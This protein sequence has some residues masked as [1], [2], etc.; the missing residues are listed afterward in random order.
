MKD[1]IPIIKSLLR[2]RMSPLL[3]ILQIAVTF[4]VLVNSVYLMVEK[5]LEIDNPTGLNEDAIFSFQMSL[6]GEGAE[7][8]VANMYRDIEAIRALDSVA[9]ATVVNSVPLSHRGSGFEVRLDPNESGYITKSA[10][11][12]GG[13]QMIETMG[14]KLIA[15][16][17]FTPADEGTLVNFNLD[18]AS[19]IVITKALA[20]TLYPEYWNQALGKTIY[21]NE[22]PQNV[23]GIVEHLVGPW[24][25]WPDNNNSVI[26]PIVFMMS[27]VNVIVRAHEGKR[28]Q[29]MRDVVELLMKDPSRYIDELKSMNELKKTAYQAQNAAY[30][31]LQAVIIGLSLITMLGVFGQTRFTV[32]KRRK[33]IG[34]R[35]ALGASRSEI[36]RYFTLENSLIN[37]CGILIGVVLT[38]MANNLIVEHFELSPVPMVYL[39]YGA[40]IIFVAGLV[41]AIQPAIKAAN[42]SP[43]EATRSV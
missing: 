43:A 34:T 28:A 27:D 15:G 31:T 39:I 23:R 42:I 6:S 1:F 17:G 21:L 40:V 29:S 24:S 8:K 16:E 35:R 36:I 41:A 18:S 12:T 5:R 4:T 10:F 13:H 7:E 25:Y 3:L 32:L 2:A 26:Y 19:G 20:H 11:F 37:I 14:L 30:T 33:Q 38:I 22:A 9:Q